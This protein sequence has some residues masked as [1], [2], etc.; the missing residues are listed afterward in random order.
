MK[1]QQLF[2]C[3]LPGVTAAVLTT[4][5][6]WANVIKVSELQLTS[7]PSVLISTDSRNLF[8][9]NSLLPKS[10]VK[11]DS[12][13]LPASYFSQGNI[14]PVGDRSLPLIMA[15]NYLSIEGEKNPPK[16]ESRF[17]SFS[18]LSNSNNNLLLASNLKSSNSDQQ[19]ANGDVAVT[20]LLESSNCQQSQPKSQ[21]ALLVASNTCLPQNINSWIA[22]TTVPTTSETSPPPPAENIKVVPP[23]NVKP[24]HSQSVDF[25]N[26]PND[27]NPSP[28]PLLYPTKAE[29]VKV[30][31][32]QPI[33]L[34]QALE[35][36]K[37]NNNDLQVSV[38]Q[39]E[40]SKSVLREAQAALMPSVDLS[41]DITNSL[42][43]DATLNAKRNQEINP[44]FPDATSITRFNGTAQIRYDLYTSGRRNGAIKEA[45]ERI[46]VQELDV[47]RQSEE[48]R[49]NVATAYYNLQQADENV[50]ISQ[51]AV[52]NAQA[53]LKD[54]VALERAGVGTRFDVLRSQVNLANSQQD[55]TSA[56]SQ[57]QIARRRLAPLLNLS[58]SVSISAADPVKLAG[59]WQRPLEQS[60]V[61]AYQNRPEL[62]RNLA[63]RN[64]SEAQRKQALASLGPQVSLVGRY[65]LLDQFDDGTSVSDGYSV[66]V[67]ATL[68]LYDG[69]AAKARAAQ[70]K[71]NIAISETQFSEQRNQIRFQVE[72]AYS[73]QASNLENVQTSNVALEQAKESLRL[74]RLRFQAGVGTQTDVINALNDLTR[75]EGNRV[76]AILDY[77]R[78]LTE[79]QRYV[80][81]RGLNQLQESGVK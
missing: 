78:A 45:E 38:L 13:L 35:L 24:T 2:H 57:Q 15:D 81:S 14:K 69:G 10:T 26:V 68:S 6:A 34:S 7:S 59:L 11:S 80:T 31:G 52:Q 70:S 20:K 76:K 71:T 60:I 49:L 12:A 23:E 3:F 39:L 75:S 51:S 47:E 48:I 28:N 4:Q 21:A 40:R 8:T 33:S 9:D 77:N 53:S 41:G 1:R 46:R 67:Q 5:P 72:Q 74:A 22:Q 55:L 64:I 44:T 25:P 79:L 62:Q 73:T 19:F 37:R 65:N 56:F 16:Y 17:V 58:Q 50:R 27:L 43:A 36:A 32:T 61:L 30:Q 42:S 29:E 66:G 63:E 54:A 18:D